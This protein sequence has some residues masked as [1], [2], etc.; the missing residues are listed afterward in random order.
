[1]TDS[2]ADWQRAT[3]LRRIETDQRAESPLPLRHSIEAAAR[4]V[5]AEAGVVERWWKGRGR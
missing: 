4:Y 5:G 1:M 2:H 3:A